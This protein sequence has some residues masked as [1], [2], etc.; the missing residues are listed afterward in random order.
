MK[1]KGCS[2]ARCEIVDA[3]LDIKFGIAHRSPMSM[4]RCLIVSTII[5]LAASAFVIALQSARCASVPESARAYQHFFYCWLGQRQLPVEAADI[6]ATS[7][8]QRPERTASD[9]AT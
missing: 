7:G 3:I 8:A 2:I 6:A 4:R 5:L 9:H 1:R